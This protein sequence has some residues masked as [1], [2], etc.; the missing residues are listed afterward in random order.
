[1][2]L[3]QGGDYVP[4]GNGG[5][6][7][8]TGREEMLSRVLFQ[9]TARRGSFPFLPELGSRFHLLLREK[10]SAQETLAAQYAAEALAGEEELTLMDTRW[11]GDAARLTLLLDWKGESVTTVVEL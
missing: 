3:L 11:D 1:M 9:L 5:F 7:T 6:V 2:M 4:D 8:V 10:P